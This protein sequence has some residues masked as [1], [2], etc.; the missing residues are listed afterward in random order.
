MAVVARGAIADR[1][2]GRTFAFVASRGFTG[3]LILAAEGKRY[4]VGWRD[5][6]VVGAA[7]PLAA[8]AVARIAMT[9][10]LINPSQ[11]GDIMRAQAAAPDRD[12]IDVIADAVKLTPELAARL[13]RRAVAARAMRTFA[14]VAGDFVLDDAPALPQQPELAIDARALVFAGARQHFADGRL[15]EEIAAMGLVFRLRDD[16]VAQLGQ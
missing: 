16:A 4:V 15:L 11:V 12:E 8:D 5:G 3:D 10:Q 1:P 9:A 7:S 2:W 14:I 13:R 6:A